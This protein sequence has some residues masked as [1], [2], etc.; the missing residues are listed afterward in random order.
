[1]NFRYSAC[2]NLRKLRKHS[3]TT[4]ADETLGK[5]DY[6]EKRITSME[7][8]PWFFSLSCCVF[9]WVLT[10]A[11]PSFPFPVGSPESTQF[12]DID[13]RYP[14]SQAVARPTK[15]PLLPLPPGPPMHSDGSRLPSRHMGHRMPAPMQGAGYMRPNRPL[16]GAGPR[17]IPRGAWRPQ[18]SVLC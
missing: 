4:T 2:M 11:C 3:V 9:V 5:E 13:E 1:M 16:L 15:K 10:L 6:L 7:V 18:R 17:G 8:S 14:T 12:G